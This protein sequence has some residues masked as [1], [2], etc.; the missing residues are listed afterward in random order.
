V[1]DH[2]PTMLWLW[3]ALAPRPLGGEVRGGEAA[4][5]LAAYV[6]AVQGH[7]VG[8]SHPPVRLWLTARWEPWRSTP[9]LERQWYAHK[10]APAHDAQPLTHT[11]TH[12]YIHTYIHIR[13]QAGTVAGVDRTACGAAARLCVLLYAGWCLCRTWP[14]L[15]P[16]R[17]HARTGIQR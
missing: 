14:A 16:S 13:T 10:P 2:L 11:H 7:V 8:S 3:R 12:T 4:D 6:A 15:P 17:T 9:P 1:F 5:R